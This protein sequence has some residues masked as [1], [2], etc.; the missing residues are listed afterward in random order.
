VGS[1]KNRLKKVQSYFDRYLDESLE[2]QN[3][4]LNDAKVI[5]DIAKDDLQR[6]TVL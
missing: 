1:S 5:K 6:I 2:K 4:D 3:L